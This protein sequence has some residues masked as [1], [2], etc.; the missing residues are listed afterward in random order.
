[1]NYE[2]PPH[3]GPAMPSF[4]EGAAISN[5]SDSLAF[6]VSSHIQKRSGSDASS[7]IRKLNWNWIRDSAIIRSIVN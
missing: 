5:L 4:C 2:A 6:K 1:M 7:R 3:E